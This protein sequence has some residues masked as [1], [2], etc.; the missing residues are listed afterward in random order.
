MGH[1]SG[2]IIILKYIHSKHMCAYCIAIYSKRRDVVV[3]QGGAY[4]KLG[5]MCNHSLRSRSRK[6][7]GTGRKG[8][9]DGDW[10][11]RVRETCYKNLLLLISVDTGTRKLLIG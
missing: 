4:L 11:E 7:Y 9:R 8:K 5:T 3:G 2:C 10:G 1:P 6:G